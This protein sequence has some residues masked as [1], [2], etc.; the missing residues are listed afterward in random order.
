ML[1][2]IL[3]SLLVASGLSAEHIHPTMTLTPVSGTAQPTAILPELS[4][5]PVTPDPRFREETWAKKFPH[6]SLEATQ[7]LH[8]R[9]DVVFVDG[10]SK[11]EWEA[12]HIPGALPLPVGEFD[13]YYLE[14]KKK[15]MKAKIIV[16]YCHG[17]GCRQSDMLAQKLVDKGF[18]NVAVFWG[19]FPAWE[20]AKLPLLDKN[21]KPFKAPTP[22]PPT[23]PD[24]Q[25]PAAAQTPATP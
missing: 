6:I 17:E 25:A 22:V 1:S 24:A 9:K 7:A 20:G 4:K 21:G 12:S 23:T 14:G 16:P 10:R 13:K 11:V 8:K 5:P 3:S 18:K 2:L 15:L 19:G